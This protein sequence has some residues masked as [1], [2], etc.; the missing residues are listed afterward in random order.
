MAV[1][2]EI[3]GFA[4]KVGSIY[5]GKIIVILVLPEFKVI[6]RPN[7]KSFCQFFS[8]NKTDL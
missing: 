8:S 2:L 3:W 1:A 7:K 4:S 6:L 5:A